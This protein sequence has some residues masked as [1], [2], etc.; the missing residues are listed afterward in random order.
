MNPRKLLWKLEYLLL[1]GIAGVINALSMEHSTFIVKNIADFVFL[2]IPSR[3]KIAVNNLTIA[4]GD[5]LSEKEKERIAREAFR[6]FIISLMEFFRIPSMLREA[7]RRFRFVGM[8]NFERAISKG[9]GVILVISHLGSWEYLGFLAYLTQ[10]P[11][12][13]IVKQIQNPYINRWIQNLRT[14]TKLNPIDKKNS[15]REIFLEL[16]KNNVVAI[17]IDQWAGRDGVASDFFGEVTSTTSIPFRIAKKTGAVLIPGY[18]LR[19]GVGH[20]NIVIQPEVTIDEEDS[21]E[22]QERKTTLKLNQLLEKQILK[23]PEQWLWTHRRWKEMK[24]LQ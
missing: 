14:E 5:S 8:E 9:H 3:R 12:S 13:V 4:Y 11:C 22:D 6:N 21:K 18:C 20:Y 24:V 15:V 10:Y 7:Q 19:T 16:K 1:R 2:L 23:Y 17:L